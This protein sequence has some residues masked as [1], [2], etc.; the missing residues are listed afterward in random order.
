LLTHHQDQ[1]LSIAQA[2]IGRVIGSQSLVPCFALLMHAHGQVQELFPA[3]QPGEEDQAFGSLVDELE[4]GI[5]GGALGTAL[6]ILLEPPTVED[7]TSGAM[8]DLE[9]RGEQRFMAYLPFSV[10]NGLASFQQPKL[11]AKAP[12]L[13]RA[14]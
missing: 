4:Q 9:Q 3:F 6:V 10:V 11:T 12:A 13:F 7:N 2:V 1:L 5:T 8:I 14:P